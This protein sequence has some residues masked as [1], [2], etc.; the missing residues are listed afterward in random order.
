MCFYSFYECASLFTTGSPANN[1]VF[2]AILWGFLPLLDR[3]QEMEV[4]S[5]GI[6]DGGI[7]PI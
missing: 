1:N 5:G 7:Y 6:G 4:E 2:K 3:I